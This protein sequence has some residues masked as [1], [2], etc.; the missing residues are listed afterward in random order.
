MQ[1]AHGAS[2]LCFIGLLAAFLN[3][4][5]LCFDCNCAANSINY[6]T[7]GQ[8]PGLWPCVCNRNWLLHPA[9][10][11]PQDRNWL[12]HPAPTSPQDRNWL[13]HPAPTSPQDRNWLLH[14]APTSAQD[15]LHS[16]QLV[17]A[18]VFACHQLATDTHGG[19][20]L[21]LHSCIFYYY[22]IYGHILQLALC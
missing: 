13:L 21:H 9:P 3:S 4:V 10:T 20:H 6:I 14:P 17:L 19:Y 15:G 5:S 7:Q 16:L 12:L 18:M 22:I 2:L 1:K 11:S 8:V